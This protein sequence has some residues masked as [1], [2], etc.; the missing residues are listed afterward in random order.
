MGYLVAQRTH[1]IGV[2]MAL[3]ATPASVLRLMVSRALVLAAVGLAIG[4]PVAVAMARLLSGFLFGVV[5][6][7]VAVFMGC[8]VVLALV[9]ALAG[10]LPAW[11]AA[12]VDPMVALRYE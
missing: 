2:R 8:T 4:L 1:E 12:R 11:R 3:G 6:L 5:S 10:Y 7:D 9:A